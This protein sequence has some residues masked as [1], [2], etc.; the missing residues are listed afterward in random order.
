MKQIL[1]LEDTSYRR[2][3]IL[4]EEELQINVHS[5]ALLPIGHLTNRID[6]FDRY[7]TASRALHERYR[8]VVNTG[9]RAYQLYAY[10]D[11][12][13]QRHGIHITRQVHKQQLIMLDDM[14]VM[15]HDFAEAMELVSLSYRMNPITIP[16]DQKSAE[17]SLEIV[18][19][20]SLLLDSPLSPAYVSKST[21]RSEQAH[22]IGSDQ[23]WIF[24][25]YL[26]KGKK[27]IINTFS[28]ILAKTCLL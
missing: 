11:I 10:L 20:L 7:C 23:D 2:T 8:A 16:I 25:E 3:H 18:V 28:P 13:Q 9:V 21:P 6:P 14:E 17:I 26:S 5:L 12:V 4:W 1:A 24:S 27:E 19:S 15:D 22:Q